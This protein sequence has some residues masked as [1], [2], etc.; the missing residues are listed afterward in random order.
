MVVG[1]GK[2]ILICTAIET[3]LEA[4]SCYKGIETSV[5]DREGF[6][7]RF[8]N[9]KQKIMFALRSIKGIGRRFANIVCKKAD[10]NMS[11]RSK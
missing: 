9:G 4:L 2:W 6:G 3:D 1:N 5:F 10:I 8:A 7:R 11:K